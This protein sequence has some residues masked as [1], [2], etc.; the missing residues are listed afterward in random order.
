MLAMR[1][2]R[3][4][5]RGFLGR[6]SK[7]N[8]VNLHEVAAAEIHSLLFSWSMNVYDFIHLLKM[9]KLVKQVSEQCPCCSDSASKG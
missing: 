7:V 8:V 2:G 1:Q 5:S 3:G 4:A 9:H 6:Q